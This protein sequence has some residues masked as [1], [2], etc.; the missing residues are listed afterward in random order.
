MIEVETRRCGSLLRQSTEE[1]TIHDAREAHGAEFARCTIVN[2]RRPER[3]ATR[4]TR[5]GEP[6]AGDE[7]GEYR[8]LAARE[9]ALAHAGFCQRKGHGSDG[10]GV[11]QVP[12]DRAARD[13]AAGWR[14][15]PDGARQAEQP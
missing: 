15:A 5:T 11:A 4:E 3:A 13:G 7:T 6:R 14:P 2:G 8:R 12:F 1:W 9:A 10:T